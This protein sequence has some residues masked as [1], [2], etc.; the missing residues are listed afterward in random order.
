MDAP[1]CERGLAPIFAI[2]IFAIIA[3]VVGGAVVFTTKQGRAA[4]SPDANKPAQQLPGK[5]QAA[6]AK[7]PAPEV[8]SASSGNITATR[9]Q[10]G[11]APS[12]S[13]LRSEIEMA[14]KAG[15]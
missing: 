15:G 2:G 9:S 6:P 4:P 14:V 1:T 13:A 10:P 8:R 7:T 12:A 11:E 3:L 5:A